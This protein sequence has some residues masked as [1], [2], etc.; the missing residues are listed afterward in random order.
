MYRSRSRSGGRR[1]NGGRILVAL[2]IAAFSLLSYC[3]SR[4][5]N[6]VTDETQY[7]G[8]SP[9]QEIALGLQAAPEMIQEFGGTDADQQAQAVLDG[10]CERLLANSEAGQTEWP[11]ECTL[12]ADSQTINAFALPGGQLFITAA[13][14]DQLETEG[15]LAG[16]MAHE[17]GHVIARHSS[18]Q[19]AKQKLTEGLTGAA[20][21]AT[22]DPDNPASRQTA[23][24]AAL[25]GQLVNMKFGRDDEL[26][27]D[28]LGVQFMVEA[29]YDPRAMIQVMEILAAASQGNQPPEFFSTH[30]NPD[31]RIARI[32]EAIQETFPNG[33]PD[34]LDQ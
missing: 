20:V 32:E 17:I 2:A 27:S 16:V 3:S 25:I 6:P 22:Y 4:S 19:I 21:I 30:P 29:G 7:V 10:V 12:L 24:V 33:V 8:I 15:Q 31:N 14:Y 1:F 11:F 5:Y 28:R 23:Q 9:E 13:L 26:Q 34:G 18:Q